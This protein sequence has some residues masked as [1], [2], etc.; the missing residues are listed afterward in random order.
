MEFGIF[1]QLDVQKK[2]RTV[3]EAEKEDLLRWGKSSKCN[4]T[5]IR[6][7]KCVKK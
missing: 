4:G 5:E 2:I 7:R 3:K 6:R 1:S